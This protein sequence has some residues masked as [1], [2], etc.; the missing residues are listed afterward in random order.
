M[1]RFECDILPGNYIY[2][3]GDRV[4]ISD[5]RSNT[6]GTYGIKDISI[7]TEKTTLGLGC[8]EITIFD[9]LGDKLTEISGS[10]FEGT[11]AT[12]G[13]QLQKIYANDEV[14]WNIDIPN[15]L[16]IGEFNLHLDLDRFTPTKLSTSGAL[17]ESNSDRNPAGV[18]ISTDVSGVTT[19]IALS[20]VNI[21]AT[22]V[23]S[24]SYSD[25]IYG[26]TSK[27][28]STSSWTEFNI[29]NNGLTDFRNDEW[30]YAHL[31]L[32]IYDSSGSAFSKFDVQVSALANQTFRMF[33]P[34]NWPSEYTAIYPLVI[35]IP[36]VPLRIY[37]PFTI[38]IRAE[39]SSCIIRAYSLK[40]F[41]F[42]PHVHS[43]SE[44]GHPDRIDFGHSTPLYEPDDKGHSHTA[45]EPIDE[46]TDDI[47]HLTSFKANSHTHT[48]STID[49][50]IS[51]SI[52]SHL[53][54]YIT[55]SEFN[56]IKIGSTIPGGV[57]SSITLNITPYL[58]SGNN[59]ISV[60]SATAGCI[61]IRASFN[62]YGV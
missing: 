52:P 4:T 47:G 31:E 32:L 3:E 56:H 16:A 13:G 33:G 14:S 37:N 7:T 36:L 11:Q 46:L 10:S 41:G 23:K 5:A 38:Y 48:E 22:V 26:D 42:A 24:L 35:D 1:E 17:S 62:S 53:N 15:A 59:K 27:S 12:V 21:L 43:I 2:N 19:G 25:T 39:Q 60:S 29:Y 55:N 28:I 6:Y 51:Y 61:A 45:E 9:L 30:V 54:V 49:K 20:G 44:P 8:S 18:T 40:I 58:R 57:V 50:A 34:G